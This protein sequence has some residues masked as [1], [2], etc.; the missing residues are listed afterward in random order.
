M[1]VLMTLL[2]RSGV[3]G[4]DAALEDDDDHSLKQP[5]IALDDDEEEK[6]EDD[7]QAQRYDRQYYRRRAM[8]PSR[9]S[10]DDVDI[11]H[12]EPADPVGARPSRSE[13][14]TLLPLRGD[15]CS[16]RSKY[17]KRSGV[18]AAVSTL[19]ASLDTSLVKEYASRVLWLPSFGVSGNSVMHTDLESDGEPNTALLQKHKSPPRSTERTALHGMPTLRAQSKTRR[20]AETMEDIHEK[21]L[22]QLAGLTVAAAILLIIALCRQAS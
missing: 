21:A 8:M 5:L 14:D 15:D 6:E 7:E 3:L 1:A 20:K 9:D 18:T 2:Q 10:Y 12:S 22:L 16:G 13:R 4:H 19:L 11:F 17:R